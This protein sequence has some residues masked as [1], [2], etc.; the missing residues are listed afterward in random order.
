V[1]QLFVRLGKHAFQ[2]EESCN[3]SLGITVV[4]EYFYAAQLPGLGIYQS[5]FW[6]EVHTEQAVGV[7]RDVTYAFPRDENGVYSQ[8][9]N[10][11]DQVNELYIK[12]I[13]SKV[14]FVVVL[15]L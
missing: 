1:T 2:P 4:L 7:A 14:D 6:D 15:Q 11:A 12:S 3:L 9:G 13:W 5:A 8:D 10:V